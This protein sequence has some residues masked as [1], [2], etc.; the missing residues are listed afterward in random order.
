MLNQSKTVGLRVSRID[1]PLKVTGQAR[2]A[3]EHFRPGMLYGHLVPATIA[4]DRIRAIHMG[5]HTTFGDGAADVL[6]L[7]G[8]NKRR[9][10]AAAAALGAP[11]YLV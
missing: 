11:D 7:S 10:R 8:L 9:V 2:Y 6:P 1:G 4:T 3:A 5:F